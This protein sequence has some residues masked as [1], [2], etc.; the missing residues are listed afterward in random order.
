M[1]PLDVAAQGALV[2]A[3]ARA[4]A[5]ASTDTKNAALLAAADVLLTRSEDILAANAADIATAE[6]DGT[7]A[8]VI[9]RLRL[10]AARV[11]S[12]ADGL[13]Q[14]AALP[15]PV[16]EV[17]DG[18]VRPN[19]SAHRARAG[20]ARRRRH[21]LREPAQRHLRRRRAVPQVGQRSV[22][23]RL[24]GRRAVQPGDRGRAA[25]RRDQGG[26]AGRRR[27][28]RRRHVTRGRGGVH[29]SARRHRLPRFPAVGRR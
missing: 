15:D 10:S 29:A 22:P 19:G 8:T 27:H 3:A 17:L 2:K 6:A 5:L 9:D 28:A 21:H 1:S 11:E 18:W 26:S 14:V 4:V 23:A 13:R 25:R 24:V 12:M 20:A 7:S 16:G